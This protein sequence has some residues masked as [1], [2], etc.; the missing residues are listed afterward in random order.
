VSEATLRRTP[1]A[2]PLPAAGLAGGCSCGA[3]RYVLGAPPLIVHACHCRDCQRL[4]GGAFVINALV[5]GEHVALHGEPPRTFP[6]ET[7]SGRGQ[8]VS[9]CGRCGTTVWSRYHVAPGD[10]RFVRA[11]TLDRPEALEPDV[12]IYVRSKLPWL[13]L[14][15]GARTFPEIYETRKVWSAG[16]QERLARHLARWEAG[17]PA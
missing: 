9:F 1:E 3:L 17:R 14:P 6:L 8:E 4:T 16:S 7:P 11:G 2:S 13:P 10:L 12:H 5:E 15:A